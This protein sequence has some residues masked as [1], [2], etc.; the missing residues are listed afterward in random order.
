MQQTFLGR[1]KS[2]AGAAL[3][4]LGLFISYENLDRAAT[5]LSHFL[6]TISGGALG[7]LPT[8]ILAVA[9]VLQ[10]CAADHQR[11][12]HSFLQHMLASSW[13]LLLVMAGMALSRDTHTGNAKP[14]LKKIVDLS[15]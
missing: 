7:A 12:L 5:E 14:L 3:A 4:G 10:A 8:I 9:R 13:P 1:V 11:F 6:G 15:I 2:I